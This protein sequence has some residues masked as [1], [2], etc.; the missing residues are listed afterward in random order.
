M[1][2]CVIFVGHGHISLLSIRYFLKKECTL[3]VCRVWMD[4]TIGCEPDRLVGVGSSHLVSQ[5]AGL[6][7]KHFQVG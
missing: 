3:S 5:R 2:N 6:Y 4:S 1:G 7:L